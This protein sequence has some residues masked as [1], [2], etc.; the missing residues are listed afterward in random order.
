M[1]DLFSFH[2]LYILFLRYVI[3]FSSY[4]LF[5]FFFFFSSRRRHTRS[6]RDWSSDVCSSDLL[7]N[8]YREDW[9]IRKLAGMLETAF[10]RPPYAISFGGWGRAGVLVDG[11][12][13]QTLLAQR[14]DLAQPY[15]EVRAPTPQLG[16]DPDAILLPMVGSGVLAHDNPAGDT[17]L[18][19]PTPATDDWPLM[20]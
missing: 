9:L 19:P 17:T 1:S 5:L 20:Y 12:R 13:L 6:K 7:Y 16:E 4:F 2:L 3:F 14:P 10:G 11:P 8:Y 18:A 15:K